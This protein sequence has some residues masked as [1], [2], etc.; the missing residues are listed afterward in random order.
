MTGQNTMPALVWENE[1]VRAQFE[2]VGLSTFD[3]F[4]DIESNSD[5]N[6]E[7]KRKHV[8]R[9]SG[10]IER[11]TVCIPF[12]GKNYFLK[13]TSARAFKC[14]LAEYRALSLTPQFGLVAPSVA[15]H[16]FD[17][18]TQRG[19]IFFNDMAEFYCLGEIHDKKVSE[20]ALAK[21]GDVTRFYPQIISIFKEFQKSDYFY[22]DWMDKHIFINPDTNQIGLI[23]LERF[24]PKSE[25]PFHWR[26]PFVYGHKRKKE[27]KKF[28][29]ALKVKSI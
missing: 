11:Q 29:G 9:Q 2:N 17:E 20:D 13:R 22:R 7:M 16:C 6:P 8:A 27:L 25:C 3:A 19:F 28:L 10:E 5:F 4:W 21:I 18:E 1:D 26:L 14:I 24:L 23:D 12:E 15:V